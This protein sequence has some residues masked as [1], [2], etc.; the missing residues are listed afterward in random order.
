M[1]LVGYFFGT[2]PTGFG[3]NS[4]A[5]EVTSG[6]DL[7]GKT[8][9]ITGCNSGLGQETL[10][11]LSLRGAS[12]VAIARSV[13]KATA[14]LAGRKGI[15]VA[16]DL[17]EPASVRHA[18]QSIQSLP[19]IHGI[20]ANAGIMA[21]P[22]RQQK[23]NLEL[24]FLT[25]HVGHFLLVTGLLH[26]LTPD[27]RVVMLSS[28]AHNRTYP[29]GLRLDDLGAERGYSPWE[30]YGQ[31]KLSN[32]LFASELA[33]R[34]PEGQTANSL[35]PGVI[36]TNLARH[37]GSMVSAALSIANPLVLKSIPQGAATQCYAAVHPSMTGIS[38]EYLADSNLSTPSKFGQD[39]QLARALWKK[40][41]ELVAE[42]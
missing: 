28:R 5:E 15:P 21:L 41:E 33:T 16:C 19:P 39:P 6:V 42:L 26:R 17:S 3:Y 4:T 36:S 1:A 32:L 40:T 35:H 22:K 10:R 13:D 23:H 18:V 14:S 20:I 29:E 27:G 12:I 7:Q 11:V 25:N 31:S 24:Q 2:G 9:L 37:M 30:A 8:Y 34:L 38:G